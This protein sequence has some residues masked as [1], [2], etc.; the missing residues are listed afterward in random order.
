MDEKEPDVTEVVAEQPEALAVQWSEKD[1]APLPTQ[2]LVKTVRVR[3]FVDK[4]VLRVM[5]TVDG[6]DGLE[7]YVDVV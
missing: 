3:A 7:I 2:H 1:A 6:A 5:Q 4:R